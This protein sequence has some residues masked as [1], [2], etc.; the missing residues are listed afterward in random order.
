MA[1]GIE[2]F[3][4]GL[5]AP[6]GSFD[7]QPTRYAGMPKAQRQGKRQ[8]VVRKDSPATDVWQ[9]TVGWWATAAMRGREIFIGPVGVSLLFV[10]PRVTRTKP[11]AKT[12]QGR[13]LHSE[14]ALPDVK[15]DIDKLERST[16]DGLSGIA[17]EDD[18]RVVYSQ[19]G[20]VYVGDFGFDEPGCRVRVLPM[21]ADFVREAFA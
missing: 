5:P 9:K 16:L 17:F 7:V 14:R 13:V 20:K 2:F 12:P 21:N 4:R 11:T 19:S 8:F 15:P 1:E 18:A 6:K 10:M 3:V